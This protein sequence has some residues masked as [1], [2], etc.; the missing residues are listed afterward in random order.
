MWEAGTL[1]PTWDQLCALA[2]LVE[3]PVHVFTMEPGA[4][5]GAPLWICDRRRGGGCTWVKRDP[6][7]AFTTEAIAAANL[8]R[9]PPPPTPPQPPTGRRR[10]SRAA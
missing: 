9:L 7:L 2:K 3:L 4:A 6:V 10:R 1:Y 5:A 8:P